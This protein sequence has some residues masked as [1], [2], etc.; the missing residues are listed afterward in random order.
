MMSTDD[1]IEKKREAAVLKLR[2][3]LRSKG[4]DARMEVIYGFTTRFVLDVYDITMKQW[5]SIKGDEAI[6]SA[7]KDGTLYYVAG[8]TRGWSQKGSVLKHLHVF[9]SSDLP[10]EI[11]PEVMRLRD[12]FRAK[13]FRAEVMTGYDLYDRPFYNLAFYG[14][15]HKGHEALEKDPELNAA[16]GPVISAVAFYEK[17]WTRDITKMSLRTSL[18]FPPPPAPPS[19]S[20]PPGGGDADDSF[21]PE[22]INQINQSLEDIKA[23]R[24]KTYTDV[25]DLI[26]DLH[27]GSKDDEDKESH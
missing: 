9:S 7:L 27:S 21:D 14:L 25:Q 1:E 10:L 26:K 2:D 11:P 4:F 18:S 22:E 17:G 24:Y 3:Y 6:I 19:G 8:Y 12:R 5:R 15:T 20:V 23:G 13:G 16:L